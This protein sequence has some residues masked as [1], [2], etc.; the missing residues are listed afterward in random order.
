M[1]PSSLYPLRSL[2]PL[3]LP[4]LPLPSLPLSSLLILSVRALIVAVVVS[5]SVVV[6]VVVSPLVQRT[7]VLF[8]FLVDQ[9]FHWLLL[10]L[11][12]KSIDSLCFDLL[13]PLRHNVL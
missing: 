12:L 13:V 8:V 11:A 7:V 10:L 9:S 2:P 6:G 3:C 4:P 5:C 1:L